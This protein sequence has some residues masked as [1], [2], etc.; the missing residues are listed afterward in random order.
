MK[1]TKKQLIII[2]SVAVLLALAVTLTVVLLTRDK[3]DERMVYYHDD[4]GYVIRDDGKLEIVSYSGSDSDVVIPSAIDSRSVA[5]IGEG[6]F[7][8]NKMRTLKLGTF[9]TEIKD[10]AFHSCTSLESV[11]WSSVL[12]S[13]DKYA[14]Y[15]CTS[16]EK[17]VIPAYL[18]ELGDNVFFGWTEDQVIE[19]TRYSANTFG[20]KAFN[21]CNATIIW[22]GE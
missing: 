12:A 22:S 2:I 5:S 10:S 1:L 6:A 7:L 11:T 19:F 15:M 13:I 9:V 17:L 3:P 8:G 18:E 16:I 4:F 14:F 20:E 21:G